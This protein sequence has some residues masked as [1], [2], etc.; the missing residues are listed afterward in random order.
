V[1]PLLLA[2]LGG[3]SGGFFFA[4]QIGFATTAFFDF[5]GLLSNPV[6]VKQMIAL[7][8]RKSRKGTK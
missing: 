4:L 3:R 5:V 2:L 7:G 8:K 6:L 1:S